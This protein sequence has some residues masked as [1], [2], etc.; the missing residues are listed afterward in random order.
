M[1]EREKTSFLFKYGQ[2]ERIFAKRV[3]KHEISTETNSM[4][5]GASI[6][7]GRNLG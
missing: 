4:G 1:Q 5:R 6:L 7:Y 2:K 3:L